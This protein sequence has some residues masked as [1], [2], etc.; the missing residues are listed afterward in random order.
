MI[1]FPVGF[2]LEQSSLVQ[3]TENGY[4]C[5]CTPPHTFIENQDG[6]VSPIA[7]GDEDFWETDPAHRAALY[8]FSPPDEMQQQ[9]NGLMTVLLGEEGQDD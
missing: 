3:W 6:T 7:R 5:G 8:R 9:L 1:E 2:C 4:R